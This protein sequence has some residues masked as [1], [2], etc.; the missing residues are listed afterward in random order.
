MRRSSASKVPAPSNKCENYKLLVPVD[1]LMAMTRVMTK[2][3]NLLGQFLSHDSKSKKSFGLVRQVQMSFEPCVFLL[4]MSCEPPH[5]IMLHAPIQC[6]SPV[7]R[8]TKRPRLDPRCVIRF[9][10]LG[11]ARS[12][13]PPLSF[14]LS[15]HAILHVMYLGFYYILQNNM[16]CTVYI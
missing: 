8:K 16:K 13:L 14:L 6:L 3:T 4:C 7:A 12:L 10:L 11:V 15:H 5:D 9:E 1:Y 2:S